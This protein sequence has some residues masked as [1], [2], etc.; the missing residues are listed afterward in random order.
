VLELTRVEH[1]FGKRF[2]SL[3]LERLQVLF[4][5]EILRE[6]SIGIICL[7]GLVDEVINVDQ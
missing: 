5:V 2:L 4:F 6:N 1:F 7:F 3:S